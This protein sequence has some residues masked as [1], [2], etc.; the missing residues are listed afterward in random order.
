MTV[1]DMGMPI[2]EYE[3][4]KKMVQES[5]DPQL[6]ANQIAQ[7]VLKGMKARVRQNVMF[8]YGLCIGSLGPDR[9]CVLVQKV[10]G[11]ELEIPSDV[12]GHG[13][14]PFEQD[15]SECKEQIKRELVAAGYKLR[16]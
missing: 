6:R 2:P 10:K 9:V 16:N 14:T 8:E 7:R 4:L 13:Y 12:L 15:L 3:V 11:A 1:D 5:D